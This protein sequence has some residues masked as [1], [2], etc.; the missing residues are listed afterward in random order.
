MSKLLKSKSHAT[1][2]TAKVPAEAALLFRM[3]GAELKALLSKAKGS[4]LDGAKWE[5]ARR[6]ARKQARITARATP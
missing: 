2:R 3:T 6:H 1:K 5:I 4:R